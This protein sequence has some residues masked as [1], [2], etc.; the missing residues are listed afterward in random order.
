MNPAK[1]VYP[2]IFLA[3]WLN[4]MVGI[5]TANAQRV[6]ALL[7]I[8]DDDP[9]IGKN[10]EVDRKRVR[11]LLKTVENKICEVE[12]TTLLSSKDTATRDGILRWV[13]HV[14]VTAE[15]IVFIYY[16]G[17]GGMKSHKETFLATEGQWIFRSELVKAIKRVNEHRL[18]ILITDCCSSLVQ[19]DLEPMLQSS[20]TMT[21]LTERVL[22][23]LFF[24]HEGFLH[25]TAAS[26]GQFGWSNA[27]TGGWFTKNFIQALDSNPDE[28]QD[29]FLSWEEV[30]VKAQ[31]DTEKTF[32]QTTFTREQTN[33]MRQLGITSQTPK[34]YSL[35]TPLGVPAIAALE[36]RIVNYV[37]LTIILSTLVIS[38]LIFRIL[39]KR[40]VSRSK[41]SS[42]KINVFS[43]VLAEVFFW[44]RFYIPEVK[45]VLLGIAALYIIKWIFFR[46][47]KRYAQ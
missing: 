35:P 12:I 15:D 8:M 13:R 31:V 4:F 14:D 34:A 29:S 42:Y 3:F 36:A 21:R 38:N 2:L 22:W 45:W 37:F 20:R 16:A 11:Q 44:I 39:K 10:V 47:K 26:E 43:I 24:E 1:F 5:T 6:H 30:F 17:H 41:L 32:S 46:K 9:S 19:S 27:A 7:V 33:R 23:N 28:N 40:H 25:I 18:T